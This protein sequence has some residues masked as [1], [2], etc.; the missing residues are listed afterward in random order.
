MSIR[1]EVA[2]AVIQSFRLNQ[3]AIVGAIMEKPFTRVTAE[4]REFMSE[5]GYLF[6]L[7]AYTSDFEWRRDPDFTGWAPDVFMAISVVRRF[8]RGAKAELAPL[9]R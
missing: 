7:N 8:F 2:D 5:A 9:F 3:S 6:H 1:A 4:D